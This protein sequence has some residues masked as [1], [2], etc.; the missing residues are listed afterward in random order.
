[1][2][3]SELE[4]GRW[5]EMSFVEQMANVG[6]EVGRTAKWKIKGKDA[7]AQNA[8]ERALEL[9]DLVIRYG[10]QNATNPYSNRKNMLKEICRVREFFCAAFLENDTASLLYYEQ[11]FG[12]FASAQRLSIVKKKN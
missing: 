3:H 6:S 12:H 4:N 10:R 8:F 5:N 1:M 2:Q 11:Y 7:M 9:I